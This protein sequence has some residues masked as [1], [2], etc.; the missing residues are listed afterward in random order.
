MS[1]KG[2]LAAR[3]KYPDAVIG[4]CIRR[5]EQ[6]GSLG[7]VHPARECRHPLLRQTVGRMNDSERIAAEW[8]G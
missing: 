3:S 6:I 7:K 8:I 1:R 4:A 5:S 2:Q